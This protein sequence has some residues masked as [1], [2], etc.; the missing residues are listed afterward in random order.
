MS[1]R[2][3]HTDRERARVGNSVA[4]EEGKCGESRPRGRGQ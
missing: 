2:T 4:A 3:S 1:R